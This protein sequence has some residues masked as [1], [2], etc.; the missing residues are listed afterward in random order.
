VAAQ[1]CIALYI[2]IFVLNLTSKALLIFFAYSW[3]FETSRLMLEI[4]RFRHKAMQYHR[5][6]AHLYLQA[7]WFVVPLQRHLHD[8]FETSR[9][10]LEIF[11]FR[12]KA[13]QY[14]RNFAHLY[15]QAFWFVVPLQRHPHDIFDR[16]A[17]PLPVLDPF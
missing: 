5:N 3:V 16:G 12:H 4:F 13:M 2:R 15:L 14:H 9:L 7:F 8:I 11:R 10:M 1:T 6:F 17:G